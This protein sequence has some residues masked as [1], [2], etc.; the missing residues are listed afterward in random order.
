MDEK[1]SFREGIRDGLPIFF[2]YIA[3]S[4]AFGIFAAGYNLSILETVLI[5]MTN[6]TSA[7]QLAAVPIF[8]CGGS[9]LELAASQLV[10]N[11]R[12]VL[13]SIS[14]SQK[15]GKSVRL[16]DR[17]AIAF[18]NTDEVFAVASSKNGHLGRKYM[19][20][21]I[22]VPYIGWCLG[23][24]L[25]TVAGHILPPVVISSLGIALYAILIAIIV[26]PMKK[27]HACAV[28]VLIAIAIG[29]IFKYIPA[30]KSVQSGFVIII[31]AI[32]ASALLAVLSPIKDEAKEKEQNA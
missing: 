27:N 14:L 30:L 25:G 9:I 26:P 2:G 6:M 10:I 13:M 12:Y 15:M 20:G 17:F 21:L 11:M 4:F 3:V 18:V 16:I 32:V 29:C 1:N 31:S 5:S 23:T 8:A 28:C 22:I 19:Y 24:L 7:G